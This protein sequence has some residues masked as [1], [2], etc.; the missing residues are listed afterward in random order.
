MRSD[1]P[2]AEMQAQPSGPEGQFRFRVNVPGDFMVFVKCDGYVNGQLTTRPGLVLRLKP[3]LS[4]SGLTIGI[5][6]DGSISGRITD[7]ETGLPIRGLAVA[8]RAAAQAAA[9]RRCSLCPD[10][11]P[12]TPGPLRG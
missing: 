1:G 11:P 9:R 12:P 7:A 8:P 5:E 2:A 10:A 3:G 4:R 6:K